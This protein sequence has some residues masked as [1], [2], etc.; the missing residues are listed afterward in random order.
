MHVAGRG[1]E[2]P[3][4]TRTNLEI[5]QNFHDLSDLLRLSRLACIWLAMI[6]VHSLIRTRMWIHGSLIS[7]K[8]SV[9]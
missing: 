7:N 4:A 2:N 9:S 3:A 1:P 5:E 6:H 8:S